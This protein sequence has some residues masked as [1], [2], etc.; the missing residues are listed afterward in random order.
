MSTSKV[1]SRSHAEALHA[2]PN[3]DHLKKQAKDLLE[4][5]RNGDTEATA[6]FEAVAQPSSQRKP[7]YRLLTLASAQHVLARTYGFS[8]WALLKEEV[9][10]R[11]AESLKQQGLPTEREQR[12]ALLQQAIKNHDAAGVRVLLGL[13]PT[14]ATGDAEFWPLG[15]AGEHDLPDIVDALIEAGAPVDA[16]KPYPHD[17]L[18]WAITVGS[19]RA[20]RRL[21]AHGAKADLW[22]ASGLGDLER[23]KAFFDATGR[24]V[25][26]ASRYGAT[27]YDS[28]GQALPKPPSD[29][30]DLISDA[31]YIACRNGQLEAARFLLDR[32]ANP[33]F[34][35]YQR[36][37]ALHWAASSGN[38]A[39]VELLLARG[40][41]PD[42]VDGHERKYLQ[43]AI[44]NPIEWCWDRGLKNALAID[45]TLL[46]A[47]DANWGPPLHEAASRGHDELVE[48]LLKAGANPRGRDHADRSALEC[49]KLAEPNERATR[50]TALLE[51][52]GAA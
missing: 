41:D 50:V 5:A 24:P 19:L 1:G 17:D 28:S 37:P 26:G 3:L 20:A 38:R 13:D 29:P 11:N 31:L 9:L 7:D 8:S 21:I 16:T 40:A 36:A 44:R 4:R 52:A 23:M 14:L 49:A 18:S 10:K 51:A 27:R 39:L 45:Q 34:E 6:Q 42:Q 48:I 15:D 12:L 47:R 2:R 46:E 33:R 22:C 35:A 30:I 43:F 32:G 25:P